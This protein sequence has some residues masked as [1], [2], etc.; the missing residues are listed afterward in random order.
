MINDNM[1]AEITEGRMILKQMRTTERL[2]LQ[3]R[4]PKY[5]PCRRLG[6]VP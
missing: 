1:P 2:L 4:N 3:K 6:Q 5:G